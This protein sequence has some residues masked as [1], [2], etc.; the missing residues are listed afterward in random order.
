MIDDFSREA[1]A[2]I[3]DN[4]LSGERVAQELDTVAERHGQSASMVTRCGACLASG[5][6][7]P[8]PS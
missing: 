1:L 7:E 8:M 2:T 4:P 3:V 6:L 5:S